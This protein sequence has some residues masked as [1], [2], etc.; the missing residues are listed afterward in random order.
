MQNVASH[1][2][3]LILTSSGQSIAQN[4]NETHRNH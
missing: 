2:T 3:V 4:D 1:S